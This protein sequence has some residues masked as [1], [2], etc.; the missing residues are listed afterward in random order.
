MFGQEDAMGVY[1]SLGV[2]RVINAWGPMT[3]IGSALVRPEVVAAMAEAAGSYVDLIDLQRAAGQRLAQMIGV[4]ACYLCGG[5]AAG[6]AIA[7]AACVTGTDKARVARLPDTSGMRHEVVMR[8]SH[9]NPYDHAIRQV[10]VRLVE[11]GNAWLTY[12]W[13]LEAAIGA[14]T[15]AV[16][17]V[18]GHRTMHEPLSLRETVEIAHAR[19]VP[20]IVDA[21]AKVP[22]AASPTWGYE[23]RHVSSRSASPPSRAG[24]PVRAERSSTL[25]STCSS[26]APAYWSARGT[27]SRRMTMA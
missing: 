8:R 10:G 17:H 2:K 26:A 4:E 5:S 14:Q 19:E 25:T 15:A 16:V 22:P 11:I 27:S 1:E 13:E 18:Y 21:A 3:R 7:T 9:R 6:L 23:T 12:D 20:V 24:R